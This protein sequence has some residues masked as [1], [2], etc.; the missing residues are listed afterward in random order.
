MSL[1]L[2][3]HTHAMNSTRRHQ[4]HPCRVLLEV[5][6]VVFSDVNPDFGLAL[7]MSVLRPAGYVIPMV[8]MNMNALLGCTVQ[9][10]Q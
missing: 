3:I 2:H 4:P 5:L 1:S 8:A 9:D 10:D 6:V 7:A